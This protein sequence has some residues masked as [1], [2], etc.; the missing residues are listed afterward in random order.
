LHLLFVCRTT[1]T[2]IVVNMGGVVVDDH[3]H[4]AGMG[5]LFYLRTRSSFFQK[6]TETGNFLHTKI[7][8][9]RLLEKGALV[10]DVE[11]KFI[12]SVRLDLTQMFDQL[13]GL[14]PT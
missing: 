11:H 13:D 1:S 7:M 5:G 9:M 10:A 8:G 4:T 12:V 2:D 3:N 6:F 14:A